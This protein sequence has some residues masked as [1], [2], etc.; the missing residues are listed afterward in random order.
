MFL[1]QH[2]RLKN[3][4]EQANHVVMHMLKISEHMW[5]RSQKALQ[6][7]A[8][9][10]NISLTKFNAK[11]VRKNFEVFQFRKTK[12][13]LKSTTSLKPTK[14]QNGLLLLTPS[15]LNKSVDV[16]SELF[17][18]RKSWRDPNTQQELNW[19]L[20][21]YSNGYYA[22]QVEYQTVSGQRSQFLNFQP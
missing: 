14:I 4:Y 6:T 10:Y 20:N 18:M 16:L 1:E 7:V 21:A 9:H 19:L 2:H 22:N 13:T 5:K 17:R 8:K 15:V 3:R 11:N 12:T